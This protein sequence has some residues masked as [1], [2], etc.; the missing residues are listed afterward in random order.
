MTTAILLQAMEGSREIRLKIYK[1][2]IKLKPA[3]E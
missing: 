3:W 2:D 1:H